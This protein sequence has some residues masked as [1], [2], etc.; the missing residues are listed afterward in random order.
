VAVQLRAF[1]A[2]IPESVNREDLARL[3]DLEQQALQLQ[4]RGDHA[5]AIRVC[6]EMAEIARRSGNDRGLASALGNQAVSLYYLGRLQE[7]APLFDEQVGLQRT[8]GDPVA[9]ATA[10]ANAGELQG[11]LGHAD[12]GL[13]MIG[14]AAELARGAGQAQFADQ[15]AAL[16]EQIRR[17]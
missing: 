8:I 5:G 12:A 9:L 6:T 17:R 3:R 16:A 2:Q 1:Q 10:L 14:E 4:G 11:R 13:A 7:A 15:I